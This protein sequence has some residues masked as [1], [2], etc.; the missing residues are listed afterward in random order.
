MICVYLYFSIFFIKSKSK[1]LY[2][3][4]TQP[5]RPWY[6]E[7]VSS[8]DHFSQAKCSSWDQIGS[9]ASVRQPGLYTTSPTAS[10]PYG[11]QGQQRP[12]RDSWENQTNSDAAFEHRSVRNGPCIPVRS[13][14]Q[15]DIRAPGWPLKNMQLLRTHKDGRHTFLCYKTQLL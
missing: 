12:L 4:Y 10:T 9:T 14:Y 3:A 8:C 6:D 13:L 2:T 1:S 7:C 11:Q 15:N 5:G